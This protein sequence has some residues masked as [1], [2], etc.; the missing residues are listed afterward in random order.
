MRKTNYVCYHS[1]AQISTQIFQLKS[2]ALQT[3]EELVHLAVHYLTHQRSCRLFVS[4]SSRAYD[5]KYSW[6][7][8]NRRCVFNSLIS[9]MYDTSL[10]RLVWLFLPWLW[11]QLHKMYTYRNSRLVIDFV[12]TFSR[13]PVP[14]K[15]LFTIATAKL[16]FSTE[17]SKSIA[18]V[19][20]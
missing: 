11:S 13:I 14:T 20:R 5:P 17:G 19:L 16:K 12:C 7:A 6:Q 2:A 15:V 3:S 8:R 9:N 10:S 18:T 4:F 1:V